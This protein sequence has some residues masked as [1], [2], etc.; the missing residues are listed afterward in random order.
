[1]I[2]H[3][4]SAQGEDIPAWFFM[5]PAAISEL[6]DFRDTYAF[7]FGRIGPD[8]DKLVDW[9]RSFPA[10]RRISERIAEEVMGLFEECGLEDKE[11]LRPYMEDA[12]RVLQVAEYSGMCRQADYWVYQEA[13]GEDESDLA[14]HYHCQLLFTVPSEQIYAAVELAFGYADRMHPF[15]TKD[16]KR[17]HLRLLEYFDGLKKQGT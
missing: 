9:T 13:E 6:S 15:S 3:K 12:V 1:V 5:D 7:I 16:Q 2:E 17:A 11:L 14:K 4:N 10:N 8:L